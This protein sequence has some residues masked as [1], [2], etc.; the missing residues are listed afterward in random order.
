MSETSYSEFEEEQ[1]CSKCNNEENYKCDYCK[2]Y[3]CYECKESI[4]KTILCSV[5][6]CYYCR[7]GSCF[8][9]RTDATYCPDCC[10]QSVLY[11]NEQREQEFND[12]LDEVE[13]IK[14]SEPYR[15]NELENALV[16]AGLSLRSDSKLC[17]KYIENDD[18][19]IEE[20]VNRMA[21]MKYLFEYQDMRKILQE[22][23]E[24]HI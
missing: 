8:N 11:E 10:P 20:I 17:K 22:I 13:R 7:N 5:G 15:R 23:E 16:S 24:E 18:G 12:L 4:E 3:F 6:D 21:Q 19:N 14:S 2:L 9:N 1:R